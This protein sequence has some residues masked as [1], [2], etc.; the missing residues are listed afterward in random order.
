MYKYKDILLAP[1]DCVLVIIDEEPQ[2]FFG[3]EGSNRAMIMNNVVGL[4]K[5]AK[6]FSIPCILSTV[7]ANQFSGPLYSKLQEVYPNQKPIDRTSLNSWE[8]ENFR[9]AVMQTGRKK[10]LIAGLWTEVCVT[11]PTL[12]A[13]SEGYDVYVIA[14]ACGGASK[15]A[16]DMS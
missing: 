13:L 1:E 7:E 14:D 11:L 10:L 4:A 16:H 9:N 6:I 3:V 8:D 12:C 5:A 2:M 15:Q